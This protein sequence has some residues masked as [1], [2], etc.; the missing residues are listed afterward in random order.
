MKVR[1]AVAL[2]VA[3]VLLA[4]QAS[5]LELSLSTVQYPE[6]QSIE[7]VFGATS[8]APRAEV[9]ATVE[10]REAQ[11]SVRIVFTKM[12]PA[13]LFAGDVTSFVVWAVTRDGK[14]ENLGELWVR[15]E[16][17]DASF[18]TGLKEFA[19]FVTAES[20]AMVD[21]PSELEALLSADDYEQQLPEAD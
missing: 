12:R 14:V 5:A 10:A 15:D 20:H 16:D 13:V 21:D 11:T 3:T 19:L 8:R 17:G 7:L 6:R 4:A 2:S 9:S 18:S 1:N